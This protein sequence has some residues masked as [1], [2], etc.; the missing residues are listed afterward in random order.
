MLAAPGVALV[1]LLEAHQILAPQEAH[2]EV[3]Q[4]QDGCGQ[5]L[6]PIRLVCGRGRGCGCDG[7]GSGDSDGD[8]NGD[9]EGGTS[10]V[11]S[12]LVM[13]IVLVSGYSQNCK[14]DPLK[15]GRDNKSTKTPFRHFKTD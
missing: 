3:E 2:R 11:N 14:G 9:G 10:D 15:V 8:G 5:V 7:D 1:Y 13:F 6:L 4:P 12:S